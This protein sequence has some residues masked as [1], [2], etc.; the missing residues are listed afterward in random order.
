MVFIPHDSMYSHSAKQGDSGAVIR[1]EHY[2][3][4]RLVF[5]TKT[6]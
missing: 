4:L 2:F 6:T 5:T 3:P 1:D